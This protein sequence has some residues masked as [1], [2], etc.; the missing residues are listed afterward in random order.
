MF[1]FH[2]RLRFTVQLMV[3][4]VFGVQFGVTICV[5]FMFRFTLMIRIGLR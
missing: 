4:V 1:C 2:V 5:L 3:R